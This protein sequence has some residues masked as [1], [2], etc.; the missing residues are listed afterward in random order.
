MNLLDTLIGAPAL[1]Y[2]ATV[3]IGLVVGSF[4]NVVIVRLPIMLERQWR[5]DCEEFLH[6]EKEL[7][8]QQAFN[9]VAPRSHCPKCG[10]SITA[11]ENIPI[12]SYLILGGKCKSCK[13]SISPRYPI[14]EALTAL[15]FLI[16][17]WSLG[18]EVKTIAAWILIAALICLTAIDLDRQ[19]LPDAITLPILWLGLVINIQN[20]FVDS[21]SAVIGAAIGYGILWLTFHL[22]KLATGKE[23]MGYGDFKLLAMLG[24]WLGWKMIPLIILLSSLVGAVIGLAMIMIM[25]RDRNLPIPFGPYLGIAG[26][27]AMLWGNPIIDGYLAYARL[28]H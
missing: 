6:P 4:L 9:L 2:T 3:L 25:G 26:F 20:V 7:P 8:S 1:L 13:A 12:V 21:E 28:T 14:I 19:L 18:T 22:F 10:H 23:G 24:A 17:L 15:S 5:Q 16:A 11:I 27:I